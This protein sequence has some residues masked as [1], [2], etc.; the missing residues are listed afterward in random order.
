[1]TSLKI[2][3]LGS[4]LLNFQGG[5]A[6]Q[7]AR[8]T[9]EED[10]IIR[11]IKE[12]YPNAPW[13]YVASQLPG[14]KTGKQCSDRW[15]G[16]LNPNKGTNKGTKALPFTPEEDQ[17]IREARSE[18]PIPDWNAI[19]S[20][21]FGRTG[22]QCL[23][24]WYNCLNPNKGKRLV[25]GRRERG[26]VV[27]L[28]KEYSTGSGALPPPLPYLPPLPPAVPGSTQ[29]GA[30]GGQ[31]DDGWPN[32]NLGEWSQGP[33]DFNL[34]EWSQGPHDFNLGEWSQGPHD[35]NL[36]EW[37]QGPYDWSALGL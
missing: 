3:V 11:G 31:I 23:C 21:L 22:E 2:L 18:K 29:E 13:D 14:G 20:R 19:A 33:H 25:V 24:R 5:N 30:E 10:R 36:G 26:S 34:G 12:S 4:L 17:I 7:R 1:M 15:H 27:M 37:S 8:F 16:Y 6:T 9:P 32:F 35:F 28:D